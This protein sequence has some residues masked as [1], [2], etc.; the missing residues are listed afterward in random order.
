MTPPIDKP[1]WEQSFDH[2]W[3]N[4][5]SMWYSK[6]E[7]KKAIKAFLSSLAQKE[8]ERGKQEMAEQVKR[9]RVNAN[10]IAPEDE[11]TARAI[12]QAWYLIHPHFIQEIDRISALHE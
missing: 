7:R 2:E 8:Y 9:V 3:D 5:F 6:E 4:W 11:L 10:A 1:T 12:E